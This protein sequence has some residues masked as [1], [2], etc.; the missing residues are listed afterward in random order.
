MSGWRVRN[1]N[2]TELKIEKAS[3][4]SASIVDARLEGATTNGVAVTDLLA[5]WQT[6][7]GAKSA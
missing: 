6:G 1:V 7:R 4:A 5:Y 2:L 3:L